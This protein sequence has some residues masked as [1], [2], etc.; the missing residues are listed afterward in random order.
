VPLVRQEGLVL[1]AGMN[2]RVAQAAGKPAHIE[3]AV[4]LGQSVFVSDLVS[5]LPTAGNVTTP[6]RR[7]PYFSVR[8]RPFADWTLDVTVKGDEFLRIE[9]PFFTGTISADFHLDGTLA[10]PRAIG[11]ATGTRGSV[12]FPFGRLQIEQLEVSL[13]EQNPYVPTLFA[14]AGTRIY[15]YDVRLEAT[16][17]AAEPRLMFTSDPPL[18]SQAVFLMLST[19]EVP[20]TTHAFTTNERAQRLAL[21]VGRNLASSLGLGTSGGDGEEKL[22][23][24]SGED[25]SREGGE[26]MY[27]QYNLDGRW[28]IVAEKDRFDAYNG[29]I[30]FR[31]VDR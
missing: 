3:G 14:T 13:T 15:G 23:V 7:P 28:S 27:V 22:V 10:E 12:I 17:N 1:R 29:G 26:T 8:E 19:G 9:N 6:D 16:G 24:R 20:D 30:K 18:S 11:R 31:V 25:F 5:L 21:F 2:V 4:D